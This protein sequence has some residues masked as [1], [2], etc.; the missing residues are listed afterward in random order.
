MSGS[1]SSTGVAAK[2]Q[3]PPIPENLI[4]LN[5]AAAFLGISAK[6]LYNRANEK[7]IRCY[8][9]KKPGGQRARM[10]FQLSDLLAERDKAEQPAVRTSRSRA[11]KSNTVR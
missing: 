1:R 10:S 6:T 3:R 7:Y 8:R 2:S 11:Q 9:H 5:E 4:P